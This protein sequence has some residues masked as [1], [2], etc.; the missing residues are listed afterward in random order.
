MFEKVPCPYCHYQYCDADWV[1]V[2]VGYVQCSPYYCEN[3]SACQIGPCD[4]EVE[5]SEIEKKTGW[6]Q[7]GR[8]YLTSAPTFQGIP[9]DQYTAKR[10]YEFG[11]LDEK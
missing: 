2:E 7:P 5:L 9:V 8:S 1:D 4:E 11:I 10:L 3:C 6:Y